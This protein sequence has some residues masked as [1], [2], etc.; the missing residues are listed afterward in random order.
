MEA[1]WHD[2]IDLQMSLAEIEAEIPD[3][4][5]ELPRIPTVRNAMG[6]RG[7][8]G[9]IDDALNLNRMSGRSGAVSSVATRPVPRCKCSSRRMTTAAPVR[10]RPRRR[11][12]RQLVAAPTDSGDASNGERSVERSTTSGTSGRIHQTRNRFRLRRITVR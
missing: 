4:P 2:W 7:L 9:T 6:Q 5:D 8:K 3:I 10:V 1:D 12:V 11:A